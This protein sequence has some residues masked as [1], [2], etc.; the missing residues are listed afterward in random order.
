MTTSQAQPSVTGATTGM[1]RA[2][3]LGAGLTLLNT[4]IGVTADASAK[5]LVAHYAAPQL[6]AL[7]GGLAVA[8]GLGLSAAGHGQKILSTGSPRRVALRSAL[9]AVSTLGFFLALRDLPFAEMFAFMA[10]M[11]IMGAALSA[12]ILRERIGPRIWGALICGGFGM[13]VLFP[14]GPHGIGQGHLFGLGACLAGAASIV[15]SR[16]ICR[17]H[18]HAFAQVFYAQLACA[19]LGLVTLPF[20]WQPMRIEDLGL[21]GLYTG[22]L[23]TTRWLMVVIVRLLPAY[24]VMQISNIQFI[25]MVLIGQSVFG[26]TTAPHVWLGAGLIV[27]SGIWLVQAQR[28]QTATPPQSQAGAPLPA[29]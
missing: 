22:F 25:W 1:Q 16:G 18:T 24:A 14:E 27:A 29:E 10:L 5:D 15:L 19:L 28:R 20:L 26:E 6:M 8:I 3:V 12:L 21:L 7:A 2:A 17:S 9:G 13:M 23:L 11:P 4:L